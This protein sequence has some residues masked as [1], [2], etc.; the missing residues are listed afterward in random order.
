MPF[1]DHASSLYSELVGGPS[2][3]RSA[4]RRYI[5]AL[6]PPLTALNRRQAGHVINLKKVTR[7]IDYDSMDRLLKHTI[8][9]FVV[10]F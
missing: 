5:D 6:S 4:P 2:A 9:G 8:V 7:A 10:K 1:V 3:P